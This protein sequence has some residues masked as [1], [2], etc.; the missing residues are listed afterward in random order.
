MKELEQLPI[1]LHNRHYKKYKGKFVLD[2][3]TKQIYK[4]VSMFR[5]V[6]KYRIYKNNTATDQSQEHI[7]MRYWLIPF[8]T[9]FDIYSITNVRRY[10]WHIIDAG[11][12]SIDIAST[13]GK[14]TRVNMRASKYSYKEGDFVII[15]PT[16]TVEALY[17]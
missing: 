11:G 5:T 12:T 3:T 6:S 14:V 8:S 9:N 15:E 1:N 4:I 16:E 13:D 10:N 7:D 17:G 2:K